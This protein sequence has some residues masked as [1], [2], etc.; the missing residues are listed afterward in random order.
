MA[1]PACRIT[2]EVKSEAKPFIGSILMILRLTVS[3]IFQPPMEVP[4]PIAV[5]AASLTQIGTDIS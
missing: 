5:A 3:M 2:V 4:R 1:V